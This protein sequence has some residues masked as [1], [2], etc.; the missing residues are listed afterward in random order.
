MSAAPRPLGQAPAWQFLVACAV[1]AAV[2]ALLALFALPPGRQPA[3]PRASFS[4][5]QLADAT[6]APQPEPAKEREAKRE[7]PKPA[8]PK[9]ASAPVATPPEPIAATPPAPA[10]PAAPAPVAPVGQPRDEPIRITAPDPKLGGAPAPGSAGSQYGAVLSEEVLVNGLKVPLPDGQ[11]RV[12]AD[13]QTPRT[14]DI[15]LVKESGKVIAAVVL[16]SYNLAGAGLGYTASG[17]CT[18]RSIRGVTEKNEDFGEQ[19]CWSS[20]LVRAQ[21]TVENISKSALGKAARG[22]MEARGLTFSSEAVMDTWMVL[23]NAN[24]RLIVSVFY[25]PEADGFEPIKLERFEESPWNPKNL[26]QNPQHAKYLRDR[27][28]WAS[29]NYQR[30]KLGF[31]A[32]P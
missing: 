12:A 6:P 32:A 14:N 7:E 31:N 11:W 9:K 8:A 28:L 4:V 15:A 3:P 30:L 5:A 2:L 24:R 10:A 13:L 27:L 29:Q 23:A 18:R 16:V 25:N 19:A 22:D 21:A 1:L 20:S 17:A 26:G